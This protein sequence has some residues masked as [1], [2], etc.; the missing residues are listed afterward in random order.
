MWKLQDLESV[1]IWSEKERCSSKMKPRLR[2]SGVGTYV[3]GTARAVPL[4]K[5]GRL[6]MHFAV[7]LFGHRLHIALMMFR[8]LLRNFIKLSIS[9][10]PSPFFSVVIL[11]INVV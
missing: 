6:V 7:P 11:S 8:L 4:L 9:F 2:A 1:V 10:L 5:V 3:S